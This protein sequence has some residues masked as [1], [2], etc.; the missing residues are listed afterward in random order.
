MRLIMVL[1]IFT[2]GITATAT[3]QESPFLGRWALTPASGGAGWLEV[4][5]DAGYFEGTLL[6]IGGSP[7]PQTRVYFDNGTLY[8]LRIVSEEVR[9]AAGNV[10]RTQPHPVMFSATLSGDTIKG[11]FQEP[12]ID[13][14]VLYKQDFEGNRIP[15]L[16]SPPNLATVRFGEPVPLFN[17]KDLQGWVVSGGAHW[18]KLPSKDP[19]EKDAEGWIP[20]DEAVS[21][22]WSVE[23]GVL[24]NNPAQKDGQP[25]IRYGNL[26]TE[27]AFED[28]SLTFDVN[29]G[30]D[31]NS[32]VYLRGIYE[33]QIRDSFGKPL[34]SHN[35]G[36]IYGRL[37]PL[38]AAEKPA[39]EWQTLDIT[40]V[41]RHASVKLNGRM[42]IDNQPL[43]GCTGGALW[44]DESRPGPIYL[45]GDHSAVQYRNFVLR[46]VLK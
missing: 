23:N 15:P 6:W 44:S 27:S 24:T 2:T 5:R 26:I 4:K 38:V 43:A 1:A 34:D 32:G 39:G 12:S 14:T 35:M 45:Q 21:N 9:D 28:F 13:G 11:V 36:A 7:E 22:G 41:D 33:V 17:G 42:I 46:P 25:Y 10:V 20:N 3:S 19:T 16:P 8:G 31:G 29:V 18:G 40:L 37:T 30:V